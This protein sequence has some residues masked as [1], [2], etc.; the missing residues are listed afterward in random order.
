MMNSHLRDI[1]LGRQVTQQELGELVG[2]S[3]Q[4]ICHIEKGRIK[5]SIELWEALAKA[6]GCSLA[7]LRPN[8]D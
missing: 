8:C 4:S 2:L 1:R 3:K 7:D 5:G 6:L